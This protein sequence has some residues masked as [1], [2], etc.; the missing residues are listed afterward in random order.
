[1]EIE[2]PHV[3]E[4]NDLVDKLFGK[5]PDPG[6]KSNV[7]K[8]DN[9]HKVKDGLFGIEGLK[10]N[11]FEHPRHAHSIFMLDKSNLKWTSMPVVK[12]VP[13]KKFWGQT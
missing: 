2:D 7:H 8:E 1:M 5:N 9:I 10:G 11:N 13:N 3:L 4:H 6:F 12:Y